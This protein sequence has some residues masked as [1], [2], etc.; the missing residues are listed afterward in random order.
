MMY[1]M[2]LMIYSLV[3]FYLRAGMIKCFQNN[4]DIEPCASSL[5]LHSDIQIFLHEKELFCYI[6][7]YIF[8]T[9]LV[10]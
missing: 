5:L 6:A 2:F 4:F 3:F 10:L 1:D 9:L 7:G 8:V